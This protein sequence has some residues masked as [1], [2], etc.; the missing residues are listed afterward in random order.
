M[1]IM[2]LLGAMALPWLAV[3]AP[4]PDTILQAVVGIRAT[5][6]EN[7]RTAPILGTEREGSGVV[8]DDRGL[9]VTIGYLILEASQV[10]V[11]REGQ[12]PR[13]ARIVAYDQDGGFGLIRPVENPSQPQSWTFLPLGD[14]DALQ[15]PT[16]LL[17]LAHPPTGVA[18]RVVARR[19][20]AGAWEYLL[21]NGLFTS[22]PHPTFGGAALINPQGELVG[23]GSLAVADAVGDGSLSPGNLFLPINRL[24]APLDALI[25][26]GRSPIAKPWLGIYTD[27]VRGQLLVSRVA[28]G[29]P[30][31]RAGVQIGDVIVEVAEARV[32]DL[33]AF[34]RAVWGRGTAGTAIPLTLRRG[35]TR[36]TVTV[37]SID[38]YDW[39]RLNPSF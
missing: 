9:I 12:P 3:A 17:A 34:Y 21:D 18:V 29:S 38:R 15:P 39:L 2:L 11:I 25:A 8:I 31:D 36:T 1:K 4:D 16:P 20:F 6:P 33:A 26:T 19:S 30:A 37:E 14:S 28:V 22:P 7:A 27:E 10:T 13:P 23:I 5:V 32:A 35:Q 24:K